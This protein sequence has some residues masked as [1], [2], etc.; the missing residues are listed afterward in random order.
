MELR[1]IE[2]SKNYKLIA[3]AEA[4]NTTVEWLT[5]QSDEEEINV[6][7]RCRKALAKQVDVYISD[8]MNSVAGEP[9]KELLTSILGQFI[10]MYGVITV[11]FGRTMK[12]VRK[13]ED[14]MGLRE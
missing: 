9:H 2:P 12:E 8:V 5:G 3:I 1:G 6:E 14:D 13:V 7:T 4:L 11:N 10:N